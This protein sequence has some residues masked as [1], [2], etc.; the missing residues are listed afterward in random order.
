[1]EEV[2]PKSAEET[3]ENVA[4]STTPPPPPPPPLPGVTEAETA[5]QDEKPSW[6]DTDNRALVLFIQ[7]AKKSRSSDSDLLDDADEAF[8]ID[9]AER[10]PGKSAINCI[11]RYARMKITEMQNQIA[12]DA[13]IAD[14]S[15]TVAE[16]LPTGE[17][18]KRSAGDDGNSASTKKTK[19]TEEAL[20][21]WTDE[22]TNM[23][24]EIVSQYPN[25]EFVVNSGLS[26]KLF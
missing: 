20:A 26:L 12:N 22:E 11:Q 23:L 4:P 6:S 13:S 10:F 8:W 14:S 9:I 2:Q 21:L 5:P 24:R 3:A 17:G 16:A 7:D 19:V 25:S 15:L 18:Q 1:M